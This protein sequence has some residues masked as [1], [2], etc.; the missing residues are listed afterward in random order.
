MQVPKLQYSSDLQFLSDW[1]PALH[2]EVLKSQNSVD[3]QSVLSEQRSLHNPL[4]L[5]LRAFRQSSLDR[6]PFVHLNVSR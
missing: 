4:K 3:L 6:H 1:Q 2:S 5:H